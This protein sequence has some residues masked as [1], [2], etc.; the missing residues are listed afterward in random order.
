MELGDRMKKYEEPFRGMLPARMPAVIRVDGKAFHSLTRNCP[1]PFDWRVRDCLVEAARAA[2]YEI[3]A[4]MAYHQSDEVSMLLVDY[5]RFDSAQWFNGVV[6]KIVS[7]AASVMGVQFSQRWGSAG[8][9]DARVFVVPERDIRNY[10]IWRQQDA[11][12]NAL[13]MAAQAVHPQKQ[14]Q[15]KRGPELLAMLK[16]KDVQFEK[17]PAWFR[18]G[19]V[20]TRDETVDAPVFSKEKDYLDKFLQVEEE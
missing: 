14:L 16:R 17:Y 18:R 1:R 13:S 9:F 19:S 12:R 7:V 2:M 11:M 10:F 5:N 8:Y 20:I 3:P 15:N 6:Q 4:R